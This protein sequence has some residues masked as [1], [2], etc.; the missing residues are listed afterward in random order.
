[1]NDFE[2]IPLRDIHLPEAVSWWPPALGWWLMLAALIPVVFFIWWGTKKLSA[3]RQKRNLRCLV[4]RELDRIEAEY[5]STTNASQL[6]QDLS[7]LVRR[8]VMSNYPRQDVAG[9]C[10]KKWESWL[11]DPVVGQGLTEQ[12]IELLVDGPYKRELA[13][14]AANLLPACRGWIESVMHGPQRVE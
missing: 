14:D 5:N 4:E 2:Q 6:L 7:I 10:G 3:R 11:R 9:L 12:S 8:V 1:M 13:V